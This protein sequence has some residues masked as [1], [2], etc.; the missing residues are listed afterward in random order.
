MTN[1]EKSAHN[2]IDTLDELKVNNSVMIQNDKTSDLFEEPV[3][4]KNEDK[5]KDLPDEVHIPLASTMKKDPT[6][7]SQ[8]TLRNATKSSSS[9]AAN[10]TTECT[11]KSLS[12]D[13]AAKLGKTSKVDLLTPLLSPRLMQARESQMVFSS[14]SP[15]KRERTGVGK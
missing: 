2:V 8:S 1:P 4:T 15:A 3:Q 12:K 11:V 5:G 6:K 13:I 10:Y 9:K 7:Q 14:R